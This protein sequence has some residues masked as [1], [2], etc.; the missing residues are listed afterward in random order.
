MQQ[1]QDRLV[2]EMLQALIRNLDDLDRLQSEE[3][4]DPVAIAH[5][6][7]ARSLLNRARGLVRGLRQQS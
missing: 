3:V 6:R 4:P 5:I 1:V 2:L 7:N